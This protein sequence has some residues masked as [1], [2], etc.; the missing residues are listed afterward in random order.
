M[1]SPPEPTDSLTS[2][3]RARPD[4]ASV[5]AL[6][7]GTSALGLT[8]RRDGLLHVPPSAQTQPPALVVLL[9]GAGSSAPAALMLLSDLADGQ[10]LVLLAPDSRGSSWDVIRGGFGPDVAFIDGALEHVFARCP[11]DPARVALA[12]FSDGASYALSLGIGNGDLF[13]HLIAFSPGFAA[14]ATAVGR[15]RMFV[16]HGDADAVLPVDRC[17]RRLVPALR[18]AGYEVAYEEFAGGHSVPRELARRAVAWM[19]DA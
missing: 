11:I 7:I 8:D 19:M 16:T 3:L 4:A 5:L 10:G 1:S 15:P 2:R 12:G 13:T 6:P 9:H 14:P 17:S 18:G